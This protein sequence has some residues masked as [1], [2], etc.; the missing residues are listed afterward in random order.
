MKEAIDEVI[1]IQKDKANLK[2]ITLEGQFINQ[3]SVQNKIS[4]FN[5]E[6]FIVNTDKKVQDDGVNQDGKSEEE[7]SEENEPI[8]NMELVHFDG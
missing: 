6:S 1:S 4:L 7:E 8:N 3:L 5:K 2:G